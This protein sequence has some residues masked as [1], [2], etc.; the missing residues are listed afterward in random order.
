VSLAPGTYLVDGPLMASADRRAAVKSRMVLALMAANTFAGRDSAR[1]TLYAQDFF[2][3]DI[4]LLVDEARA[5]AADFAA[6]AAALA[7]V[8]AMA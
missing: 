7:N 8:M 6:L 3:L 5:E 2:A 1:R 4:E